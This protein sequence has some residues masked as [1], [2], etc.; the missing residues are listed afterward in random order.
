MQPLL[1]R[2]YALFA[3]AGFLATFVYLIGFVVGWGV[4]KAID[5]GP[6][7][8]LV[9]ALAIDLGLVLFFGLAHSVMARAPFKRVWTTIIP[10]AAE[11]STY[12]LVASAQLA[13][14]CWQWR[15]IGALQL[16]TTTGTLALLLRALSAVG[17]G[18]ALVSTHLIDHFE[19]FGLRQAFGRSA[20]EPVFR[21][22]LLYRWVRH[23]LYFGML[24]AFWSAPTM[25]ASHGLFSALLSV[26]ILIGVRHEER[27]LVR[28]FGDE[29]RRYQ[30][31]VPMLIPFPLRVRPR[32]AGVSASQ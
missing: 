12:V 23:P 29:Y 2:I 30:A 4:P 17:W 14:L 5:D 7:T 6:S 9:M 8:S 31:A 21:T 18:T 11:R 1:V 24:L 27:D 20:P 32:L 25:S 13:L 19:L 10:P 3:Y 22:P 26:Y 15:P 16:W 28:I